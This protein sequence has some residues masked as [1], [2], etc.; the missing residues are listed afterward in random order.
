MALPFSP[1]I[2]KNDFVFTSGQVHLTSG[3][4]LLEGTIQEQ[5]IQVMKNLKS[6]L[7]EAGVSLGNVVKS[8]VYITDMENYGKVS[9]TYASFFSDN[10]PAREIVCVKALPLGASIEISM[11]ASK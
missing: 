8:T 6:V 3:G 1:S 4:K 2:T 5:T 9:D 11:I 7:N 10:Y